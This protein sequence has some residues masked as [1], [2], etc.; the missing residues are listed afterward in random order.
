M[1]VITN[2]LAVAGIMESMRVGESVQF[3]GDASFRSCVDRRLDASDL[4]FASRLI[5]D[6]SAY[7]KRPA[8]G[9]VV[10]RKP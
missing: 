6:E 2:P 4:R 9:L 1:N 10:T 7:A 5:Y 8:I 3:I